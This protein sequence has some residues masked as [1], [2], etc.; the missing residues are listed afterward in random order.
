F[1]AVQP[2]RL[3]LRGTTLRGFGGLLR[4][5]PV[6]PI[7]VDVTESSLFLGRELARLEMPSSSLAMRSPILSMDVSRSNVVLGASAVIVEGGGER[8]V[9]DWLVRT[10]QS[11]WISWSGPGNCLV[12]LEGA[13]IRKERLKD[14]WRGAENQFSNWAGGLEG[15]DAEFEPRILMSGEQWQETLGQEMGEWRELDMQK[16]PMKNE[17]ATVTPSRI[18]GEDPAPSGEKV[19]EKTK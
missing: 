19:P 6:R 4:V 15:S 10:T 9:P 17:W 14:W 12:R 11:K 5:N 8:P 7:E 3:G 1:Q 2:G 13:L 16:P 18:F